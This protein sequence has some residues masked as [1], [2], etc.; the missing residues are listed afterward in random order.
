MSSDQKLIYVPFLCGPF[1]D[2]NEIQS[3][4]AKIGFH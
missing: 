1:K 4:F 2:K 3:T